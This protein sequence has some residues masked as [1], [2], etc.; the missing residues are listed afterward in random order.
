MNLI[1][2]VEPSTFRSMLRRLTVTAGVLGVAG[3]IVALSLGS[4]LGGLGVVL[5]VAIGFLNVRSI[6]RQVSRTDVDPEASSKA[7]RR[8]VGSRTLLRLG[9]I[10]LV[11]LAVVVIEA[12]LGIGIVVGL[13][14]FQLAFVGN[15]IRAMTAQGG[16]S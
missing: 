1:G 7:L 13:V 14:I 11:V 9:A 15:V 6:D 12:P 4:P 5:G 3:A 16:L 8:M 2:G 10:T